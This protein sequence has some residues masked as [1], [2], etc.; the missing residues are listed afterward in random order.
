E[1]RCEGSVVTSLDTARA[2]PMHGGG[3]RRVGLPRALRQVAAWVR[4]D[5]VDLDHEVD[6]RA[7]AEAG[8]A[9]RA[10]LLA[11]LRR[12]GGAAGRLGGHVPVD[13]VPAVAVVDHDV[14]AEAAVAPAGR[15]DGAVGDRVERRVGWRGVVDAV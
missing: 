5:A 15:D 7:G 3:P 4:R 14:V 6:V 12:L 11:L 13:R 1:P 8:A 10:G 2:A 9:Q